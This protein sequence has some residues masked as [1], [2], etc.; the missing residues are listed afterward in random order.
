MNKQQP[1]TRINQ[2]IIDDARYAM[3]IMQVP[4]II[5]HDLSEKQIEQV[6][7]LLIKPSFAPMEVIKDGLKEFRKIVGKE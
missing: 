7:N 2:R 3:R 5:I 6:A 4:P 1:L